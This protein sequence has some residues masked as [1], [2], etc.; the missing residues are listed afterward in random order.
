M[1]PSESSRTRCEMKTDA[2]Q[3]MMLG[4]LG[5]GAYAAYR[6]T[7][8]SP[9]GTSPAPS[10]PGA[11]PPPAQPGPD[12]NGMTFLG[13]PL[14]LKKGQYY[15][16][17]LSLPVAPS[18]AIPP[19]TPA[20]PPTPL[21]AVPGLPDISPFTQGASEEVLGRAL[22]AMGFG[23]VRVYMSVA[24]LPSSGFPASTQVNPHAGTRWFRAMWNGPATMDVPR[25]PAIEMMWV[26][27]SPALVSSRQTTAISG[28]PPFVERNPLA[29]GA[30]IAGTAAVLSTLY[31]QYRLPLLGS[32]ALA[33]GGLLL[34]LPPTPKP[35]G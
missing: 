16:G 22:A 7:Q 26:T 33:L 12:T 6:M 25:P 20:G 32:G 17:R 3:F 2:S 10:T 14:H 1:D 9:S 24:D 11:L 30:A 13:N 19:L 15:A 34:S 18:F 29:V 5:L 4:V 8:A 31:P 23:D 21:G 35:V 27:S 28:L